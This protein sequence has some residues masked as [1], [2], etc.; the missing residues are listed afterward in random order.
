[1][2]L[3]TTHKGVLK[4]IGLVNYYHDM[5][6]RRSHKLKILT[7]LM[8]KKVRF[9]WTEAEQKLFKQIKRIVTYNISLDYLH[10]INNLKY[11]PMISTSN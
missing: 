7:K 5:W 11:I 10:S 9:K 4:F 1:M 6:A 2:S 8:S 3:P